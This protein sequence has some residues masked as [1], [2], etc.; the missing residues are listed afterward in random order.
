[1]N[2]PI[3]LRATGCKCDGSGLLSPTGPRCLCQEESADGAYM[4]TLGE[5]QELLR[6]VDELSLVVVDLERER[7][8]LRADHELLAAQVVTLE[9][10]LADQREA[11]AA[12]KVDRDRLLGHRLTLL[13]ALTAE[14]ARLQQAHSYERAKA[15][16]A[17]VRQV[18]DG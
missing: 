18:A 16:M 13:D 1:M 14:A 15:L 17:L 9:R 4:R 12:V 6:T 3:R 10:M 8:Q 5:K 2:E 7:D 11:A